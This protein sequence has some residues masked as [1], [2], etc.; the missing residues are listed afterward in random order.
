MSEHDR[1]RY[2]RLQQLKLRV[3]RDTALGCHRSS[4]S[5]RRLS[6]WKG[7]PLSAAARP[8]SRHRQQH[9]NVSAHP[10]IVWSYQRPQWWFI[11]FN[12]NSCKHPL[13]FSRWLSVYTVTCSPNSQTSS[14]LKFLKCIAVRRGHNDSDSTWLLSCLHFNWTVLRRRRNMKLYFHFDFFFPSSV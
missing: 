6:R 14:P 3:Q 5:S 8:T 4:S 7:P 9:A 2:W 1:L 11:L 10:Q 12:A 13:Y